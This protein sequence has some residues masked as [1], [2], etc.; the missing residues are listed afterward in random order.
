MNLFRNL[1]IKLKK[2]IT[3]DALIL[4]LLGGLSSLSLPP[5]NFFLINFFTFSIF[6]IFLFKKLDT[7]FNKKLFFFYGWLFGFGYFLTNIY[8]ITI[9]LT[10]DQN[11]NFLIPFVLIIIPAFLALFYGVITLFFYI[12]NFKNLISAFFLFSLLFGLI[13]YIRGNILSGFPWNLIVYSFSENIKFL[14]FISVVGTYSF[15]LIVISFFTVPAIYI[16]R[17]SNKEIIVIILLLLLPIFLFSYNALYKKNFLNQKLEEN[18]YIIRVIGSNISLDRFYE[19]TDTENVINELINLSSPDPEKKIFFLWPEGII[20]DTYQDELILYKDLFKDSFTKNH[21]IGLGI[22][23]RFSIKDQYKYFNSFSVFDN[24]LNLIKDYNKVNLVPFG[25]FLPFESLLSKIGLKTI[26]NNFGSFTRGKVREII[27]IENNF[28]SFSFLP[29]ICYEIIYSGKL[30]RNFDFDYILNISEDGWF[31]KSVG[32][33]QHLVHSIFRAIESGKYVI[34]SANNGQS[35]IINP[36]GEIEK[37]IDF[38]KD[39]YIDF[40]SRRDLEPTIFS[41]FGN[42][43]FFVLI[44]LYIFLIF[45]FNRIKDE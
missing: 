35:I 34:R 24:N 36:L 25:E 42:K 13:E 5:L 22:T 29:L 30:S 19:N 17:R 10:F 32:P 3:F 6:F 44:L 15:N 26:T 20:P 27:Q 31:G 43:I 1:L 12:L 11:F 7:K 37:K 14:S 16:L 28:Q 21:L 18:P 4:L 8:W 9:S 2:K 38:Q 33:K 41:I 23:S 45:S 40:T 39:G